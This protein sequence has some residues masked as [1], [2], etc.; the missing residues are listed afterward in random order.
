VAVHDRQGGMQGGCRKPVVPSDC[1]TV[2]PISTTNRAWYR[3][4]PLVLARTSSQMNQAWVLS[5]ADHACKAKHMTAPLHHSV[6][7]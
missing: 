1:V 5:D 3:T 2:R 6:Q 4:H 7:I